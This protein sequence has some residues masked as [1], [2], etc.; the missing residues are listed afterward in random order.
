MK[1]S[2]LAILFLLWFVAPASAADYYVKGD[3]ANNGTG[4]AANCA[5]SAGAAGAFNSIANLQTGWNASCAAGDTVYIRAYDDNTTE[6]QATSNGDDFRWHGGLRV[7]CSG[8]AV[9]VITITNYPGEIGRIANGPAGCSSATCDNATISTAEQ[10]YIRIGS[11]DGL[12]GTSGRLV[13]RGMIGAHGT[14]TSS[15]AAGIV[16]V[17]LEATQGFDDDGNW[18][19]IRLENLDGAWVHHN[20]IHDVIMTSDGLA[21]C[22]GSYPDHCN[23]SSG[24]CIKLF[25]AVD[26]IIEFNT[27]KDACDLSNCGG[28]GLV[29]SQAGGIDDKAD[30]VR[31]LHRYNYIEDVNVC[32]R[33]QNQASGGGIPFASATG[34][35]IYGNVCVRVGTVTDGAGHGAIVTEAGPIT[36]LLVHHNTFDNFGL[37]LFGKSTITAGGLTW[38]DNI[39]GNITGGDPANRNIYDDGSAF[40]LSVFSA[41]SDYNAYDSDADYQV[42]STST[43][44]GLWRTASGI[45]ANSTEAVTPCGGFIAGSDSNFHIDVG[46]GCLTGS[47]TGNQQGAYGVTSCVGHLCGAAAAGSGPRKTL[48]RV[49]P[50]PRLEE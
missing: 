23:A 44:I 8:T 18:S 37:V 39:T 36:D 2:L 4:A 42:D 3:C 10:S 50:L 19:P 5:V 14:S 11:T 22:P 1:R 13:V 16:I 40:A 33:I 6:H 25:T 38:R 26:S 31:N 7:P 29:A 20:N 35:Q 45:D 15:R 48:P 41:S 28:R 32:V 9:S 49:G 12:Y 21:Q 17:G 43:S 30:S 47:S 34:T 24:G 46:S 27:C